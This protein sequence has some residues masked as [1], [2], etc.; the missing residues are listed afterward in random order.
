[1]PGKKTFTGAANQSRSSVQFGNEEQYGGSSTWQP[2]T[3]ASFAP[4]TVQGAEPYVKRNVDGNASRVKFGRVGATPRNYDSVSAEE[5]AANTSVHNPTYVRAAPAP[6]FDRQTANKTNY[7]LGETDTVY[8]T[9]VELSTQ[10][11]KDLPSPGGP[12]FP[13]LGLRDY[14][15]HN[16]AGYKHNVVTGINDPYAKNRPLPRR[17]ESNDKD[18]YGDVTLC[19][20]DQYYDLTVQRMRSKP[21]A[22]PAALDE[23]VESPLDSCVALRP[24]MQG[25]IDIRTLR[26]RR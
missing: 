6:G 17:F 19:S 24:P 3:K 7:E 22:P 12:E 2:H 5:F 14:N 20:T 16:C 11:P 15:P 25:D 9:A 26:A 18:L 10:N 1:M 23:V 8:K 4:E 13:K 21:Q